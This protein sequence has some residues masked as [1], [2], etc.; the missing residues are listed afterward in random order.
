MRSSQ[1]QEQEQ[2]QEK[3]KTGAMARLELTEEC[4]RAR[5]L[6]L[7]GGVRVADRRQGLRRGGASRRQAVL[8]AG[9][10]LCARR[11]KAARKEANAR[12]RKE[13]PPLPYLLLGMGGGSGSIVP[14]SPRNAEV[15]A[16][17]RATRSFVAV[18]AV[19]CGSNRMKY[20]APGDGVAKAARR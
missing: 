15:T 12:K 4:V 13:L 17:P 14:R 9:G 19:E 18:T 7:D 8:R 16:A 20:E 1:E 11:S 2:E 5:L 10:V 3:N 6:R